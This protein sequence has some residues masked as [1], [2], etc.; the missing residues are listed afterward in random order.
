[1]K[2]NLRYFIAFFAATM[3]LSACKKKV[4][5]NPTYTVN[6]DASFKTIDDYQAALIGAYA[7]LKSND[8]YSS[9]GLEPEAFVGLPDMLSDNLYE[10]SESLANFTTLQRWAYT[11]DNTNIENIWVTGYSIIQQAN[12]VLRNIDKLSS[13]DAGAVNRIKGQAL[14]LRAQVHFDLLRWFGEDFGRNSTRLGLPYVDVFDI[15]QKPSRLTV[16]Q[17]LDKIETDL[18]NAKSLLSNIDAPVQSLTST[19]GTNRAYVDSL[20]VDAMLARM[21]N[22]S[23]VSDSAIKYATYVIDKRPLASAS[24]FPL[25]WQDASTAEV[26]WSVKFETGNSGVNDDVYYVV[27]NR[28]SYR[29]TANLLALYSPATDI[30]YTS[31]FQTRSGRL[32]V[33]KYLAKQ[34]FLNKPDGVTDFKVYR[35]GEMYLIRAEAYALKGNDVDALT[36]LNT[37]RAARGAA[38]GAE[39]GAVLMTAIFNE[40][41][42]EL[43]VEGQRFFDLKRTIRAI[44]RT[45]NCTNFCTLSSAAREWAFP[46]PQKEIDA[47]PNIQQ[48][49]GY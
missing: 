15:E 36:D 13:V 4:D 2:N 41:R 45:T 35:T 1:M 34:P 10:T 22:Y 49:P 48:N 20:V 38:V 31:Y 7:R 25:I 37:L 8:W 40:R 26:I 12:L 32:V 39:T 17:T 11:S 6:G 47:N 43:V 3:I 14:A 27:G 42:K 24:A 21:Y 19:A 33:S 23:G 44:N 9:G 16:K 28:A 29:P 18:H 46:I 30:R 5:L